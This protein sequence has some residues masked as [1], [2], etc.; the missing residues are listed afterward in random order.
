MDPLLFTGIVIYLWKHTGLRAVCVSTYNPYT[1]ACPLTLTLGL[2]S[3]TLL[4]HPV[5]LCFFTHLLPI[6]LLLFLGLHDPLLFFTLISP[7]LCLGLF[8][9]WLFFG[10]FGPPLCFGRR[11]SVLHHSSA[12][13]LHL[14]PLFCLPLFSPLL[15]FL[16]LF[17]A[18]NRAATF[19]IFA[20]ISTSFGLLLC[21]SS[22]Y[23]TCLTIGI[24]YQQLRRY[25][26]STSSWL[27]ASW[28]YRST[29]HIHNENS[30]PGLILGFS[31]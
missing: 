26:M 16:L 18:S 8:S 14:P 17:A 9:P 6:R 27:N 31:Y 12:C 1:T 25:L 30:T 11:P 3:T 7:L 19:T 20:S 5:S 13:F 2:L 21:A 29:C 24:N 15:C 22:W 10:L 28:M 23:I 4:G